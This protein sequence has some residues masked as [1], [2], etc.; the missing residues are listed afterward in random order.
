MLELILVNSCL[1]AYCIS[2]RVR[3]HSVDT[4]RH[5]QVW[6]LVT[7]LWCCTGFTPSENRGYTHNT[8]LLFHVTSA[9]LMCCT[10]CVTSSHSTP[11]SDQTDYFLK[12]ELIWQ[13]VVG[14]CM[15]EITTL[16][17]SDMS[18]VHMWKRLFTILWIVWQGRDIQSMMWLDWLEDS[19][20]VSTNCSTNLALHSY[21]IFR[22]M[23]SILKS[24]R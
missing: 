3:R 5:Q 1:L 7:M 10:F 16:I 13:S 20:S 24:K 17:L 19:S 8:M 12:W 23:V 4:A 6:E 11:P 21:D 2:Q 15:C 18:G 14:C 9:A 22:R